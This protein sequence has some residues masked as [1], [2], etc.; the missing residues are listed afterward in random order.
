MKPIMIVG[1]ASDVGKS[2]IVTG[3]CRWLVNHGYQPAPFKAQNMSLNSYATPDGL[4]IGR[5]Q[6]VQAE[7]CKI[8][9]ATE[10]NPIL[11]KPSSAHSSQIVLNGKPVGD[12]SAKEYFL[13]N[14]KENLFAAA[15]QAFHRLA[16][17]HAP[18]VME[19]AGSISELNLKHRD[20]VNM[21]MA[22]A[23][24]A[25]VY[26]VADIDKGGV[27]GS[28][29]GTIALL[30][31]WE[32]KLLK[33][34]IINKFRGD[35]ALFEDGKKK[36]EELTGY[37]VLGVLPY[38]RSVYLEE[39]DSVALKLKQTT[40]E[41]ET[42]NVA[43]VHFHYLSNYT[44]F[45]ALELVPG[46]NVY[47]TRDPKELKKADV[48][49]LPGTKNTMADLRGLKEDGLDA[50][51]RSCFG[52]IKILGICGGYQ[53][54]GKMINDPFH[55][56]NTVHEMEGLNLF[57]I[58]TTMARSKR[59]V[60]TEFTFKDDP[61]ACLGYEIHMGET[62]VEGQYRLNSISERPEGYLHE[63]GAWGT[64]FHGIFDNAA[65]VKDLLKGRVDDVEIVD[66]RTMKET[67]YDQLADLMDSYLDM[68]LILENSK[69][70]D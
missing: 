60:Q 16:V 41:P 53:M 6:A 63:N 39:E 52:Q 54:M 46:V 69:R 38:D 19:G 20:I 1:T 30:E 2:L 44:D 12:Q 65:V 7:A 31:D 58:N 32:K 10:M 49:I 3:I 67:G 15:K 11:L 4:E 5:A 42:F 27:F 47:Y 26:L 62:T 17:S 28:V 29:Y 8:P 45:N 33:G 68:S 51:I 34:I 57:P 66:Y 56:E 50:V 22:A 18:I 24:D 43:V 13:G 40:H 64:Y 61:S 36:L 55:V 37:P 35:S 21:R 14:N 25:D 70:D 48:I 59:T 9:C 23:A